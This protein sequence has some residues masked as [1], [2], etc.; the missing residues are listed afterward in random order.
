MYVKVASIGRPLKYRIIKQAYGQAVD[1]QLR[2]RF[3][4]NTTRPHIIRLTLRTEYCVANRLHCTHYQN[5]IFVA[6]DTPSSDTCKT[7]GGTSTNFQADQ[8][9]ISKCLNQTPLRRN[10]INRNSTVIIF[11]LFTTR[12]AT[13]NCVPFMVFHA[14]ESY[15]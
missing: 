9:V 12:A 2:P 5:T 10:I 7:R 15:A 11:S 6:M 1:M 8:T 3:T 13:K 14:Y 4:I